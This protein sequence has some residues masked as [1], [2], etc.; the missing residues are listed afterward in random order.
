[1]F[2]QT[3][4][5]TLKLAFLTTCFLLP[6]GIFL[7]YYLH[8]S[9]SVWKIFVEVL[10]WL[11][12]ILPPTV[13]G[14][15]LLLCFSPQSSFGEFLLQ[16]FGI[17]LVF[18]FEGVLFASLI[19]GLP[20]MVN[21]IKSGLQ[22]LSPQLQEASFVLGKGEISTLFAVLLPNT[23]PSLLL[24]CVGTFVHAIG[25]FGVVMMIGGN[26]A[27][28][29]RVASIAIYDEVEALNYALAHQYAFSLFVVCAGLLFVILWVNKRYLGEK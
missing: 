4:F 5:L 23:K 20:F 26:V 22:S 24:A 29:T 17:K 13:L 15:Y 14:F 8:R 12:L 25:E 21:P 18:S 27:G 3:M 2:W 28:E 6:I 11:P 19:F 7:A 16:N 1:M 9:S 10:I